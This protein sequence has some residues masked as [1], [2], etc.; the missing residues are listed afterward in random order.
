VGFFFFDN[1]DFQE[2][3]TRLLVPLLVTLFFMQAF[4]T[5]VVNLYVAV[6][7]IIWYDA[8][9][10]PMVALAALFTPLLGIVIGKKVTDRKIMI[11]S[12]ILTGIFALPICLGGQL[13]LVLGTPGFGLAT[14][15]EL[16]FSTLVVACYSLFLPSYIASQIVG[17]SGTT[18]D[19]EAK[20]FAASFS[21]AIAYDILIR[22]FNMMYDMSRMFLYIILQTIFVLMLLVLLVKEFQVGE[23][24]R[25]R[26][27]GVGGIAASRLGGILL[28]VGI[29]AILFLEIGLFA[30]PQMMLRWARPDS[31]FYLI[32]LISFIAFSIVVLIVAAVHL[33]RTNPVSFP[34][35]SRWSSILLGNLIVM[36]VMATMVFLG[37][38]LAYLALFAPVF[39]MYDL[40]VILQYVVR[41]QFKWVRFTVLSV[42]VFLS[43]TLLVLFCFMTGFAYAYAYLG[44]LGAIFEGQAPLLLLTAAILLL[45]TSTVAAYKVGGDES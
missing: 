25:P 34:S 2:F 40:F 15:L 10:V 3:I 4:R 18:K 43:L 11:G 23:S 32:E 20:L 45:F 39:L 28:P 41:R 30:N 22:S 9:I 21:L 14:A 36:G 29:G 37:G 8:S 7:N 24:K 27:V 33:L 17:E 16:L 6:W 35:L 13:E 19:N 31:P 5:F 26:V 42:A 12:G 1:M 38:F 44:S